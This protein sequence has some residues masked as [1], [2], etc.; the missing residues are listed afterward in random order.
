MAESYAINGTS[1]ASVLTHVQTLSGFIGT[2][3]LRQSDYSVPGRTGVVAATP[4]IGPRQVSVGGVVEGTSRADFQAK[5]RALMNLCFGG[6]DTFTLTRTLVDTAGK[7][8]VAQSTARYSG[9]LE[10]AEMLSDRVARVAVDFTLLDGLWTDPAYTDSGALTSATFSLTVPGDSVTSAVKVR[11]NNTA[12][13]QRL[14]NTTLGDWVQ[15]GASTVASMVELDIA[16]FT[17]VQ[18]SV[19]KIAYVSAN[20][21]SYY[22]MRLTPG[23]NTFALTGGGQVR[24]LYKAAWL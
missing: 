6:G 16:A 21:T 11:F 20:T 18:S 9:G 5:L 19:N 1:I 13:T 3:S 8:I 23:V 7:D 24:V 14:T 10:S 17:A 4:W 22:W 12:S 2:P 15:Y